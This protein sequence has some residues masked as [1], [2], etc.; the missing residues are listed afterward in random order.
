MYSEQNHVYILGS[1]CLVYFFTDNCFMNKFKLFIKIEIVFVVSCLLTFVNR[2][3]LIG[4]YYARLTTLV[5]D[6]R[7]KRIKKRS[8]LVDD[9]MLFK[10]YLNL[11]IEALSFF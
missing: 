10:S 7:T 9:S 2:N 5:T 11:R 4:T 8:N 3:F 1:C 6:V